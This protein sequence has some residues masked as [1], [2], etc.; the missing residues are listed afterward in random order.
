MVATAWRL[1]LVPPRVKIQVGLIY[2]R[3]GPEQAILW[4]LRNHGIS[5]K[6]YQNGLFF[7]LQASGGIIFFL[8]K[9]HVSAP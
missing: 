9:Y 5:I 6:G 3:S 1:L 7:R 4:P 2:S 8:R